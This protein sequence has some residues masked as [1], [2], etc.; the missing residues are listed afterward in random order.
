MVSHNLNIISVT[1]TCCQFLTYEKTIF[2]ARHILLLCVVFT[3]SHTDRNNGIDCLTFL[4][5]YLFP[6]IHIFVRKRSKAHP[7]RGQGLARF[8]WTD[9]Q[10][11]RLALRFRQEELPFV[12]T[13]VPEG[14]LLYYYYY[15]YYYY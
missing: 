3:S 10:Q 9:L 1:Y 12:L 2:R 6:R 15:Y 11:R 5:T 14:I 13:N 4:L 7:S 8:D